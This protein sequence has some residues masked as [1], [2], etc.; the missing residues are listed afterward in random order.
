MRVYTHWDPT[1]SLDLIY[2]PILQTLVKTHTN[3]SILSGFLT[4]LHIYKTNRNS[5]V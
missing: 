5:G 4:K 3:V 1:P 2:S